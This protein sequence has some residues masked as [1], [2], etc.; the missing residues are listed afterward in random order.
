MFAAYSP[1]NDYHCNNGG[2][3]QVDDGG[4]GA[5]CLCPAGYTGYACEISPPGRLQHLCKKTVI[6][7]NYGENDHK[8]TFEKDKKIRWKLS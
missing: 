5:M 3:C 1:C 6:I 7:I 2:T 4:H 8:I